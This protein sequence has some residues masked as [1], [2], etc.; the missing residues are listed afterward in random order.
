MSPRT[1]NVLVCEL[2]GHRIA[3]E[4]NAI[5][6][7]LAFEEAQPMRQLDPAPYLLGTADEPNLLVPPN[8][9]DRMALLDLPGPPTAVRIGQVL[10]AQQWTADDLIALPRWITQML[11]EVFE[12]ACAWM[13]QK[14]VWL[15]N[16]DTLNQNPPA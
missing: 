16:L 12:P 5:S 6:S 3:L 9:D 14:V 11:P 1:V 2:Q 8:D 4:L 7:V 15:L 10:G 13:D